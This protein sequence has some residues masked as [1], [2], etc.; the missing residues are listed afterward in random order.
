MADILIVEDDIDLTDTYRDLLEE[1]GHT[2]RSA[3]RLSEA[4]ELLEKKTPNIITLDL[5]LPGGTSSG[6]TQFMR[7]AKK[8]GRSRIIVIS[9][10]PEMMS[11]ADWMDYIDLVLTKP[12][13][14][15]QLTLMIERLT[16]L[17]AKR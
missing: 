10:H 11:G 1:R 13:D 16:G 9:G 3:T 6:I 4:T 17:D 2:V 14:N 8:T 15:R 12:V 5:S 7:A